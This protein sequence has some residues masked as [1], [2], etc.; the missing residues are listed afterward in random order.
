MPIA[1]PIAALVLD[2]GLK[3][4]FQSGFAIAAGGAIPEAGYAFLAFWG[5]SELL[6]GYPWVQ[7]VARAASA[8]ILLVLAIVFLKPGALGE[9]EQ[10]EKTRKRRTDGW[11]GFVLGFS[12]T[13][14]N[15]TL[16]A[17]W[18]AAVTFLPA[19]GFKA[20]SV[21]G[22]IAFAVSA[23]LGIVAWFGAMLWIIKTMHDRF[24]QKVLEVIRRTMGG[25]LLVVSLWFAGTLVLGFV[26]P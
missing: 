22:G 4:R 9:T 14:M 17:T 5:F 18:T 23:S 1:G 10:L 20:Y 7:T 15:P 12:I 13:A 6:K 16:I 25:F 21:S 8:V 19:L 26:A 11:G 2:R 24:D 3:R